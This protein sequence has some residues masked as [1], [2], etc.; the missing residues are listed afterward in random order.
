MTDFLKK[1]EYLKDKNFEWYL[2]NHEQIKNLL[3][4]W[5][6]EINIIYIELAKQDKIDLFSFNKYL[7]LIII[8][9]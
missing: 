7:N 6:V 4:K 2:E 3:I 5:I 9:Y 1:I 8:I